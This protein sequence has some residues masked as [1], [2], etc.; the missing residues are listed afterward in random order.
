MW[1]V[2]LA[3]TRQPLK[4]SEQMVALA[5]LGMP[6]GRA[7]EPVGTQNL[8]LKHENERRDPDRK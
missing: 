7:P 1:A 2:P 8:G 3:S 6:K 4:G 5:R